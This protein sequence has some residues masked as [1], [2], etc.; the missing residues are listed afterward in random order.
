MLTA[1]QNLDDELVE[2]TVA[3]LQIDIAELLSELSQTDDTPTEFEQAVIPFMPA[4]VNFSDGSWMSTLANVQGWLRF[5]AA[6]PTES[7]LRFLQGVAS[8]LGFSDHRDALINAD[9]FPRMTENALGRLR[10]RAERAKHMQ[11]VFIAEFGSDG[12]T[13]AGATRAWVEAWEE[14][15]DEEITESIS[16]TPVSAE[17][18]TWRINEFVGAAQERS[19]NLAPSYQRGDVWGMRDRQLLIESILRGIPLPSVIL[20]KQSDA[21]EKPYEVV[22]GKQ[23]LTSILRFVGRHPLA[24]ERVERADAQYPDRELLKLFTNNYPLFK[25]VWKSTFGEVINSSLEEKYFFPFKLRSDDRG[26]PGER[27]APLQ[28]KYYTEIKDC[29][30]EIA[31]APVNVRSVFEGYSKYKVPI[32]IYNRADQRQIHEVFNLYNKQG[33]HLNAEEIRNAIFHDLQLTRAILVAAGDSEQ[34]AGSESIAPALL[35]HWSAIGELQESL[36]EYRFG[37]ARYRRTKVLSW[38]IATLLSEAPGGRYPSTAKHI[39]S[40]L[41]R[42]QGDMRDPLRDGEKLSELFSWLAEAVDVHAGNDQLWAPSFKDCGAGVKWQELQLLGSLV[43]IALAVAVSPGDIEERLVKSGDAL[44]AA[45][46][47]AAWARPKKTQ[48]RTQWAY[49]AY[50]AKSILDLLQI[51]AQLASDVL[52]KKFGSSG[53]ASLLAV[54]VE[55]P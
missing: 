28:G 7:D 54:A 24:V 15:D 10:D 39:D 4:E 17:A 13:Q 41:H 8:A 40:L 21:P 55:H 52:M 34:R 38:L 2:D 19:L 53:V 27:L 22:D 18:D 16:T 14:S 48:T 11:Q 32:I 36:L 31:D 23:R 42:V 5:E 47:S 3:Q 45:S 43:G 46:L 35:D 1:N 49:I 50:V 29:L 33:T 20:L 44:Y 25:R 26:L 12:G 9:G 51:D 37:T 30:I 6:L